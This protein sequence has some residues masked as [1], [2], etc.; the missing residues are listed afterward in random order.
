[1]R[2]AKLPARRINEP[3][4]DFNIPKKYLTRTMVKGKRKLRSKVGCHITCH[5]PFTSHR[6]HE[7]LAF[8]NRPK[9]LSQRDRRF[10]L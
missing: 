10:N 5:K 9:G 3:D 7:G 1:M 4:E 2:G 8:N 6:Y